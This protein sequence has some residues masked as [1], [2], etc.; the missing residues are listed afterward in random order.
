MFSQTSSDGAILRSWL[1]QGN[2]CAASSEER[3]TSVWQ[4]L[5]VA[6]GG[7]SASELRPEQH[8]RSPGEGRRTVSGLS[9][10]PSARADQERRCAVGKTSPR[11]C[12]SAQHR[13]KARAEAVPSERSARQK[14]DWHDSA[15]N[16]DRHSKQIVDQ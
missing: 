5:A 13:S 15:A 10:V 4:P 16:P 8:Q 2:R 11:R 7:S 3:P 1:T 14:A 6:R 9:D 12:R